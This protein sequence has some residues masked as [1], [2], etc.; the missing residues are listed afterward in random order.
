MV[1][2]AAPVAFRLNLSVGF[3]NE[4]PFAMG[5]GT[6]SLTVVPLMEVE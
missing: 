4:A 5:P 3:T 2:P 1:P 6:V